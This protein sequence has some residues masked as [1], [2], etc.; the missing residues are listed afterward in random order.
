M[1]EPVITVDGVAKRYLRRADGQHGSVRRPFALIRRK[2]HWA[3]RD[4]NFSVAD[5][6]SVGLI[7][8]NGSGKSTLLRLLSG[9]TQPTRGSVT[10]GRR[11]SGLLTLG[12]SFQGEMSGT[13]NALTGAILAGLTRREAHDRLDEIT[14]FAELEE[15]V[16]QPLRTFSDGMRLRLAFA[17]SINVDP[18][19]L[20][21][22]EIL[23]VG[24]LRFRQK[25]L[26]RLEVLQ[27]EG[28][29]IVISSHELDQVEQ[30][31][32][33]TLW[34]SEG[35]I[36]ADGPSV[37]V[38]EQYRHAMQEK[39]SSMTDERDGF[40]RVGDR[41]V[42]IATV[43]INGHDPTRRTPSI[44]VGRP[45]RVEI[46]YEAAAAVSTAIVG[47]SVHAA[48]G[49]DKVLD[50]STAHS[51]YEVSL[52]AGS[53]AVGVTVDRL[54]LQPGEYRLDVGIFKHDWEHP[55]DYHF[56]AYP[57]EVHGQATAGQVN[58]PHDWFQLD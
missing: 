54:D 47:V 20:L 37:A 27:A 40:V 26:N 4:V 11:V 39:L 51:G 50:L 48:D 23:A 36:R 38:T 32:Q 22:D 31:C 10:L 42:Q 46:G 28:V 12:D 30:L 15:Q 35:R 8:I 24:D 7:G 1:T 16:H 55:F 56:A 5:G 14:A 6:E 17:I 53:G 45:M 57:F 18:E 25:C 49:Q 13:E 44:A 9:L 21:I 33:R 19:I 52:P 3:L 34:L 58:P 29:T 43:R 41:T 2:E